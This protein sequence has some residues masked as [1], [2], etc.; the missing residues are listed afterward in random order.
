MLVCDDQHAQLLSADLDERPLE[1]LN[2]KK[3]NKQLAEM[4]I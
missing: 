2:A 3:R 4:V 1:V